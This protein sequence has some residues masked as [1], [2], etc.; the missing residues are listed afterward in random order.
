MTILQMKLQTRQLLIAAA[1][2]A[3]FGPA[4]AG[5]GANARA[6]SL[7]GEAG[8]S[9][10]STLRRLDKPDSATVAAAAQKDDSDDNAASEGKPARPR[11]HTADHQGD[12][13]TIASDNH[14]AG[15]EK[16]PGD[17]V[18]VMG[19]LTVDGSVA[20]DAV[21][22][23]GDN[24]INGPVDGDAVAVMGD[25]KLGPKA[26]VGGDV[27]CIGGTLQRDPQAVI[28][29]KIV[30]QSSGNRFHGLRPLH[31]FVA[32]GFKTV[33]FWVINSLILALYAL[34]ALLFPKAVRS[35]GDTLVEHPG[36]SFLAAFLTVLALPVVFIILCVT[37]IGI[38]L[39]ILLV[40]ASVGF[41]M[42][43]KASF[44]ALVGRKIT[45]DRLHLSIAVLIGGLICGLF[46]LIPLIGLMLTLLV[47]LIMMGCCVAAI[48]G[49]GEKSAAPP[50]PAGPPAGAPGAA[51]PQI[52]GGPGP[53]VSA[54][55]A[56]SAVPPS[57]GAPAPA[58]ASPL[59]PS[60]ESQPNPPP[61]QAEPP[62]MAPPPPI[63][64]VAATHLP[65]AT[66]GMPR[67][68][69]WIR[70]AALLI[71]LI[72]A[73]V[74]VGFFLPH[75]IPILLAAYAACLWKYR[76]STIGGI[77]FGLRVVRM[78]DR[79][80][81]WTTAIVRALGCFL[82]LIAVGIGFIWVA[83][84]PERQSWHDKIAGTTVVRPPKGVSLI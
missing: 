27:V 22:V 28:E 34:V 5:F 29:G 57:I 43:G 36:K 33:W 52:V 58:A 10:D 64:P 46:F 9:S 75:G 78:D 7:A 2:A 41:M 73:G 11:R 59:A 25:L 84:D 66:A 71:D 14:I 32:H 44:Y 13:V 40:P 76:G 49:A 19:D 69:F 70:T 45:Q 80:I 6:A 23:I 83:F 65:L 17:A 12:R 62:P 68:G 3:F 82:S 31:M 53:A 35:V 20:G 67:A 50:S 56:A 15:D 74:A 8:P 54:F 38:P 18:A 72:L 4:F 47:S 48:F 63:P 26:R 21:A 16:V 1:I 79:P 77:V 24:T 39:A 51:R 60:A 55:A 42:F 30:N 81:D 61:F 37:V